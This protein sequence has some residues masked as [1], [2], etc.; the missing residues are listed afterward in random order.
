MATCLLLPSSS[1]DLGPAPTCHCHPLL[2]HFPPWTATACQRCC[3][4]RPINR[5]HL[6]PPRLLSHQPLPAA[7]AMTLLLC[8]FHKNPLLT[9]PTFIALSTTAGR[10]CNHSPGGSLPLQLLP[11]LCSHCCCC[12]NLLH[13]LCPLHCSTRQQR[14]RRRLPPPLPC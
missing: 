9:L 14:H 6:P 5:R 11:P 8:Q 10:R 13:T 7:C 3:C 12:R 4:H 2:D 1:T